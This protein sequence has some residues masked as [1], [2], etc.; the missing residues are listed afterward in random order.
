MV[1][2]SVYEGGRCDN[3][4]WNLLSPRLDFQS[5]CPPGPMGVVDF[6]LDGEGLA[7][8]LV[9]CDDAG[10]EPSVDLAV[11]CLDENR[12]RMAQDE[13]RLVRFLE[14]SGPVLRVQLDVLHDA[15]AVYRSL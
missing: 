10:A 7:Q 9:Y 2:C 13:H 3:G 8:T 4:Q 14:L 1:P 6:Q 12:G 11:V 15:S 5:P